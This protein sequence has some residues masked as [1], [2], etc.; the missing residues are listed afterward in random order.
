MKLKAEEVTWFAVADGGKALILRNAGDDEIPDFRVVTH[1]E[2]DNPPTREQGAD[3]PG[4]IRTPS[5]ARGAVDTTDWHD[6]EESRF[7]SAFA[8]RLNRA[9]EAGAYDRLA[10]AAPPKALG[11]LRQALSDAAKSRLFLEIDSDLTKHPISSI[12]KSYA[13]AVA[14][15][16]RSTEI[17]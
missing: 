12:E 10:I 7:A 6:F 3:R 1:R 16:S 2:I 11:E 8:E 13:R 9:A 14:E 5:G 15:R 4:R 17:V